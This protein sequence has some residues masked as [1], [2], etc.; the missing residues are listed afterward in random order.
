MTEQMPDLEEVYGNL[1]TSWKA[2]R[3]VYWELLPYKDLPYF[4]EIVTE[5]DQS[6]YSLYALEDS[7]V[8]VIGSEEYQR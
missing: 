4:T 6:L 8:N 5:I 1:R 2:L 7:I 3:R